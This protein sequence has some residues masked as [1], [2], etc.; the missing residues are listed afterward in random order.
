MHSDCNAKEP[1]SLVWQSEH[2]LIC[3]DDHIVT[4]PSPSGSA[5]LRF[6]HTGIP[7]AYTNC[8][9]PIQ[10]APHTS[11]SPIYGVPH[12][13]VNLPG[14][15]P[16]SF[17]GTPPMT[18][19]RAIPLLTPFGAK[20]ERVHPTRTRPLVYRV[21]NMHSD[22]NAKERG[23]MT[24]QSEHILICRDD[25]IVTV[26]SPSRSAPLR[27]THTGIP[28]ASTNCTF[29][30]Q[31][32]PHTSASHIYG[33]PHTGVHLPGGPS[34]SFTGTPPMTSQRAI[35]LLTPFVAKRERGHHTRTRTRVYGCRT[36]TLTATP[37]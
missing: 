25:H 23:S 14:G 6:T 35:R 16:H 32:S 1:G 2:K 3:S 21:P 8:T 10:S 30:I 4:L 28:R 37:K 11:A 17:T 18:S 31:R 7:R 22:R 24:W 9:S 27:F 15:P 29:P 36:C 5:P 12:T 26:S 34:H 19:Q 33:V 13:G 20:R